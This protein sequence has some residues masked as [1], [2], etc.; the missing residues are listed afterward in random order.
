MAASEIEMLIPRQANFRIAQMI[1]K[2]MK[3]PSARVFNN[4]DKYGNS[5]AASVLIAQCEVWVKGKIKARD[6]VSIAIFGNGFT[7]ESALIRW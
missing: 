1:Q 3:L 4:I 5:I 6:L 7:R 2:R